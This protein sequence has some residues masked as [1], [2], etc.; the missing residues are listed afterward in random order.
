MKYKKNVSN[1]YIHK[2]WLQKFL[3]YELSSLFF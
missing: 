2:L 3:T 1:V